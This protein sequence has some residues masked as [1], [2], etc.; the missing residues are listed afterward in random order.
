MKNLKFLF[1]PLIFLLLTGCGFLFTSEDPD[2]PDNP[3]KPNE[4]GETGPKTTIVFDNTNGTCTAIVYSSH[5]RESNSIIAEVPAGGISREI[6]WVSG[7]SVPF[8]FSY[9]MSLTGISDFTVDYV[10]DTEWNQTY[11]RVDKEKKTNITITPI[12]DTISSPAE[13]F[14]SNNSYIIIQNSSS[15]SIQLNRGS[16]VLN[17]DNGPTGVNPG[18]RVSYTLKSSD[19]KTASMYSLCVMGTD[20]ALYTPVSDFQAGRVYYYNYFNR[21]ITIEVVEIKLA[22]LMV[23]SLSDTINKTY[24]RFNN[25]DDFDVSV[26]TNYQRNNLISE[27]PAK[28]RSN[29]ILTDPGINATFYPNYNIVI[30]DVLIPYEGAALFA[31]VDPK[32]TITTPTDVYIPSLF[33]D[34]TLQGATDEL[35]K[36]LT[37]SVYIKVHNDVTA[38]FSLRYNYSNQTPLDATSPTVNARET[39]IYEVKNINNSVPVSQFD[40]NQAANI[41]YPM[42]LPEN[43]TEFKSGYVYSFRVE[44]ASPRNKLVLLTERPLTIKEA[45]ALKPPEDIIA[46]NLPSGHVSLSWNRAGTESSYEIYRSENES[47]GYNKIGATVN[48][49]YIDKTVQTGNTYYYKL[50]SV[51]ELTKSEMSE[52][53]AFIVVAVSTLSSPTGVTATVQGASS[54]SLSWS[55]VNGANTYLIYQGDSS[56]NVNT[57]VGSTS[58]SPFVVTGLEGDTTYWFTVSAASSNAESN[59]SAAVSGKTPQ[60][61]PY[62][63]WKDDSIT[64]GQTKD[65]FINVTKGNLYFIRW[66]DSATGNRNKTCDIVVSAKYDNGADVFLEE[67]SNN[68][69]VSFNRKDSGYDSPHLFISDRDGSVKITVAGYYNSYFGTY[70]LRYFSREGGETA[71]KEGDW[72]SGELEANYQINS[73]TLE[74][75]KDNYYF[76][77]LNRSGSSYGN[78]TKTGDVVVSAKYRTGSSS[79]APFN[80]EYNMWRTPY[81]FIATRDDVVI[82]DVNGYYNSYKGT[83]ELRYTTREGG[84]RALTDGKWYDDVITANK[85]VNQYSFNVEQGKTYYVWLNRSGSSYGNSTKTGDMKASLEYE[86]GSS[87]DAPFMNEYNLYNTPKS[88]TAVRTGKVILSIQGYYDSYV[89]TYAIAYRTT[90]TRP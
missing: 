85:Q 55:T 21:N 24:V 37:N 41:N 35:D 61:L 65:Y 76:I 32:K 51:R 47:D 67:T 77:W 57:Y 23:G 80:R 9:K 69:K 89:G 78:G 16:A 2:D 42:A 4:P 81:L 25:L 86:T 56:S 48:T 83:Y 6:E 13:T 62:D 40:F 53:S 58:S 20:T 3:E 19:P 15:R 87:S 28:G 38:T 90:S 1:I 64:A 5:L 88:F 12:G 50:I 17:T 60:T 52:N 63:E 79:D 84:I 46:R 43:L 11:I 59:P 45:F 34:L 22:N 31:R 74:V 33:E 68:V 8:F 73:Y 75:K 7:E 70:S 26:Y 18:E 39:V 27:V 54:I 44:Q 36:P 66:E 71:L 29:S 72:T 10:A 82:L 14:L 30:E 49:S